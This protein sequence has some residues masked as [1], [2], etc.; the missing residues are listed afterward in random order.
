MI[1]LCAGAGG[2]PGLFF[3]RPGQL[4]GPLAA[5]L[6]EGLAELFGH[7]VQRVPVA[8]GAPLHRLV[9]LAP[10]RQLG[11]GRR[12]GRLFADEFGLH[13]IPPQFIPISR[14][15]DRWRLSSAA[16]RSRKSAAWMRRYWM[17]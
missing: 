17:A 5:D 4:G 12:I 1:G 11:Q 3:V 13:D 7:L 14:R 9:Q 2:L 16:G 6:V 8:E 15:N 10:H